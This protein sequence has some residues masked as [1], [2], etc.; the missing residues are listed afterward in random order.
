[1]TT[2]VAEILNRAAR[3]CSITA[4]SPWANATSLN[5]VELR[6]DFMLEA[7]ED[8]QRRIDWASPMGKQVE[9]T[10]DG[11][12]SY[13]LPTNYFR[14]VDDELGIYE[15]GTVRRTGVSVSSDGE[16]THLNT[17]GTGGGAR[18]YKI[19]GYEGAWTIA[20]YPTL[21]TGETVTLSYMSNVWLKNGTTEKS[22]F[23]DEDDI[24][25]FPRRLI[26]TGIV[27]RFRK[28]KGL[29]FDDIKAEHEI[30]LADLVNRIRGKQRISYGDRGP[31]K[32]M[33]YPVPDY[34]PSS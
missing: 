29:P 31:V 18:F 5:A 33:R 13:N 32:P 28:R 19:E 10:G 3:Q 15:T 8:L 16:W 2:K 26:E 25:L 4:P 12:V 23:T 6:D 14:L 1:M 30:I 24:C 21:E 20:F 11:S 34:I 9:I 22:E 7:V 27:Y 17:I